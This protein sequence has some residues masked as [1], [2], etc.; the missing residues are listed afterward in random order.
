MLVVIKISIPIVIPKITQIKNRVTVEQAQSNTA[1][2]SG[3]A[4]TSRRGRSG[5]M[6][7]ISRLIPEAMFDYGGEGGFKSV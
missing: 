1:W 2:W 4:F 7:G 6:G 3:R 5:E